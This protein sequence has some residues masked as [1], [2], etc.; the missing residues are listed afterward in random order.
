MN[1]LLQEITLF[2]LNYT[3]SNGPAFWEIKLTINWM[4]NCIPTSDL[5]LA[6]KNKDFKS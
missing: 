6:Q 1:C 5:E 4:T 2:G 3:A